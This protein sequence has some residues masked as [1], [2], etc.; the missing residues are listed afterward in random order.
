[1]DSDWRPHGPVKKRRVLKEHDKKRDKGC[2]KP[3]KKLPRETPR[4][5]HKKEAQGDC[6]TEEDFPR[7]GHVNALK[8]SRKSSTRCHPGLQNSGGKTKTLQASLEA[9]KKQKKKKKW[10]NYRR[11]SPTV[12]DNLFLI[13]QRKKKSKQNPSC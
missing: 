8:K 3:K 6:N 1:M 13:K 4:R 10:R 5:K 7:G 11:R 9:P 2:M 12:G